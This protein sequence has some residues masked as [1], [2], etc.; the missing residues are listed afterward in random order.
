MA[1]VAVRSAGAGDAMT[2]SEAH[3][4][5]IQLVLERFHI[6]TNI[7]KVKYANTARYVF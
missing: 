5:G 6:I 3:R 1:D 4:V 7:L 2:I